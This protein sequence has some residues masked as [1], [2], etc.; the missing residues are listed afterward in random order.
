M[1]DHCCS[2]LEHKIREVVII[3]RSATC[4]EW[5]LRS[6]YMF[7]AGNQWLFSLHTRVIHALHSPPI[8]EDEVSRGN[9]WL[10][11]SLAWRQAVQ[12][13]MED[14]GCTSKRRYRAEKLMTKHRHLHH[15]NTTNDVSISREAET[16]LF[17]GWCWRKAAS[18]N[19]PA[20]T[21]QCMS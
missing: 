13:S 19:Y 14:Q 4:A 20:I 18:L 16:I 11:F 2:Y 17:Y 1:K 10:H 12:W 15:V 7:P 21:A 8:V 5:M 6:P 9:W 3:F